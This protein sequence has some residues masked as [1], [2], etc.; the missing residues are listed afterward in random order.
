MRD[1]LLSASPNSSRTMYRT[2]RLSLRP[3]RLDDAPALLRAIV[4]Q[5]IVRNLASAPWPYSLADAERLAGA[6]FNAKEPRLF[7]FRTDAGPEELI[8]VV[9]LDQMPSGDVELGYWIAKAHWNLGYASEVGRLM[10]EIAR[11]ELGLSRLV[12]GYFVD[13]PASG[14]VLTKLGFVHTPGLI[15]RQSRARGGVVACQMCTL[16]L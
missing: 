5:D 14:H 11:T 15:D 6:P 3:G 12:A 4:D 7:I 2:D 16:D 9:G 1:P 8:G 13:N 10:I